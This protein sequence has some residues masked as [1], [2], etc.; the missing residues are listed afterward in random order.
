[1]NKILLTGATGFIGTNFIL[2]LHKKYEIIALV[3][4]SSD[5]SK[6]EQFCQ[7][8]RYDNEIESLIGLFKQER[9]DGVMHLATLYLNNHSFKDLKQLIESNIAFGANILE[10]MRESKQEIGFFI[11]TLTS[12]EYVNTSIYNPNSF[13][14]ATKRAFY[15]MT[16]YYANAM[17]TLFT[18]LLLYDTY[19]AN[20]TRAKIF[21]LWKN[22]AKNGQILEMS[23]GEQLIDISYVDDVV[24]GFDMLIQM[25][26]EHRAINNQI[27]TLENQRYTL[28]ELAHLFETYTE[29]KLNIKWGAKPYRENEIFTPIRAQDSSELLKLPN[30]NPKVSLKEGFKRLISVGGGNKTLNY[31]LDSSTLAT[32]EVA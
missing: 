15:D 21:T 28:Q 7:I 10:S 8:Y 18:H 22:A 32:L 14:A 13:Y 6:I 25:C 1:M 31:S 12:F 11:N 24:S 19:G 3:R 23:K 5:I 27:Y 30:W 29:S 2:Q 26:L 9:F 16:K 20:D 17:P 4:Q